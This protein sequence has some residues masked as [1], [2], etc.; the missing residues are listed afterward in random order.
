MHITVDRNLKDTQATCSVISIDG[1]AFCFGL[2]NPHHNVKVHGD[3]RIPNGTYKI[4][5]KDYGGFHNK[6]TH[7]FK[8]MHKGML[9]ILDVPGFTDILIHI[10]N[11]AT[12]TH[13]CLLVGN[14]VKSK[15]RLTITS[16]RKGYE[17]LY[18]AV[19]AEAIKGDLSITFVGDGH[20]MV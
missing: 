11:S 17:R 16:S 15:P 14:G 1:K 6:Y 19:I 18:S 2:E 12:D 4:G 10:G 13:G 3:T 20:E 7:R 9:H 5:V 8:D